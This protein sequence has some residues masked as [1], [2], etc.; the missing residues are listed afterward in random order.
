M[1]TY[2]TVCDQET[3]EYVGLNSREGD[4]GNPWDCV[5]KSCGEESIPYG[6]VKID[7]AGMKAA[8]DHLLQQ[9]SISIPKFWVGKSGV[10]PYGGTAPTKSTFTYTGFGG[11]NYHNDLTTQEM[12]NLEHEAL[13]QIYARNYSPGHYEICV[14]RDAALVCDALGRRVLGVPSIPAKD[15]L[16]G[17][18]SL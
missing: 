14:A 8:M 11:S 12:F 4:P 13:Q 18:G 17:R 10:N 15:Y 7:P 6:V 1:I 5:N 3:V 9:Q 16:I 2:C